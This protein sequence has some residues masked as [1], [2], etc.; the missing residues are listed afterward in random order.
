MTEFNWTISVER[1][2]RLAAQIRRAQGQLRAERRRR[3]QQY[4][5]FVERAGLTAL[6]P[7]ALFGLLVEGAQQMH[8]AVT[9]RRWQELGSHTLAR[10]TSPEQHAKGKAPEDEADSQAPAVPVG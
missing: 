6:T 5:E 9:V 4:G 7:A 10:A 8:E 3:L 1:Q 2:Q